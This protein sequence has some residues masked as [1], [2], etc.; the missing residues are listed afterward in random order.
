MLP[1]KV[2][3]YL[4]A[5]RDRHLSELCEF[6]RIPS[7]AN[8]HGEPDGCLQAA[9]WLVERL[10]RIG[11][12]AAIEPTGGRPIVFA[13]ASPNADA[14]TVLIYGHY[15]VQPPDPLDK[16]HTPP[17]EPSVRDGAVF[18][19]GANDDKGQLYTHIMA[20]EAWQNAAG[21]PPVN[22]KMLLEGEEEQ[23]SPNLE[24]YVAA[25]AGRL[26]AD[27]A[28]ISD[29]EFFAPDLPCLVYGLRGI[30]YAEI[31]FTGPAGDLHSG[32]HGG[33]VTNPANALAQVLAAMHDEAGR[34]TLPGFYEDVVE[35]DDAEQRLWSALPFDEAGYA[36]SLGVDAPSGGEAGRDVLQRRWSRPTLDINGIVSG[37]IEPGA[38]TI[39]PAR[40]SAKVSTRLAPDQQ[41]QKVVDGFRRFLT[42]NT[43]A[44]I[45]WDL[46]V[47]ST[48]RPVLLSRRS[49]AL[50]AASAALEEAFGRR[51]AMI[52]MGGSVPVTELIQ[53]I[54]GI[55][56]AMMGY[57]LPD[58][59]IHAPN[60]RFRLRQFYDGA[61]ASAAVLGNIHKQQSSQ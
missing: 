60:E 10:E 50:E 41:P 35:T 25:N 23:S 53:R 58:D 16:W 4:N 32:T 31:T 29:S 56:A 8:V 59:N 15:D 38:K 24:P 9:E 61:V 44:G 34:V 33:A 39:I 30:V 28:V 47:H 36:R 5:N 14:P 57:G 26:S 55:D 7:I 21:G 19:R 48:A 42:D 20:L 2:R 43:P 18:A 51:P 11:L 46:T 37:Y 40:A 54:L 12:S 22:V 6:L 17:F 13:E 49:P 1:E 52:R 45:R 27:A 3:D